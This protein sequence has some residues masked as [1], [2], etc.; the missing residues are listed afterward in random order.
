MKSKSK[1]ANSQKGTGDERL[2]PATP[3]FPIQKEKGG[4]IQAQFNPK[5]KMQK[6]QQCE[7]M[8]L[9]I[10]KDCHYVRQH[11]QTRIQKL[12]ASSKDK[13]KIVL[14]SE[15]LKKHIN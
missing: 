9:K 11:K 14:L 10:K 3:K 1:K 2:S 5:A 7:S 4:L 13:R 8:N 12:V 6:K 15:I